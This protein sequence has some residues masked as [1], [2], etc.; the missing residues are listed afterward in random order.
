MTRTTTLALLMGLLIGFAAAQL[1]TCAQA[2]A[3]ATT[4][5][6][7]NGV[8]VFVVDGQEA[9]RIDKTGLHVKG[10]IAY[11]GMSTDY[12]SSG[13]EAYVKSGGGHHA[14]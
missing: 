12:G 2:Q 14:K 8:I 3:P 1:I 4:I 10:D 11:G 6:T 13:F 9:A 7:E 5:Q